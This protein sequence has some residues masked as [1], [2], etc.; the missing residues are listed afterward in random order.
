LQARRTMAATLDPFEVRFAIGD[1][2]VGGMV[3]DP[4]EGR[5]RVA[6]P[7]N[8]VESIEVW[9]GD[10]LLKS[11]SPRDAGQDLVF[12]L[13]GRGAGAVWVKV[14]GVAVDPFLGTPRTTITSP[15]WIGVR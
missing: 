10:E 1:T 9:I 5:L 3:R 4:S 11:F 2:I 8:E 7:P 14:T 12:P 15:I 13:R 6:A